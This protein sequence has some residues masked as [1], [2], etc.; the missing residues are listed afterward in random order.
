MNTKRPKHP[1]SGVPYSVRHTDKV[2]IWSN[3]KMVPQVSW[4][5]SADDLARHSEWCKSPAG[6]AYY[7]EQQVGMWRRK[8]NEA[9][10][11]LRKLGVKV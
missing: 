4:A 9:K 6:K 1:G 2:H 10:A 7:R 3:G 5:M 11:E 8:L